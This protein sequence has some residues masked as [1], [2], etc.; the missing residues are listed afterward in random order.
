MTETTARDQ[1]LIG[2]YLAGRLT[3]TEALMVE[4]RIVEDSS[5]RSEVELS[6]A[7]KEGFRELEN[8]GQ[9]E[10]LL[11]G[12]TAS[13][14][15]R[16]VAIAAALTAAAVGFG[17]FLHERSADETAVVAVETLRFER[18][19]GGGI[20]PDVVWKRPLKS[21]MVEL[22]LDV[23]PDPAAKYR[24]TVRHLTNRDESVRELEASTLSSGEVS[25]T[26]ESGELKAG[27]IELRL[28]PV[29]TRESNIGETYM[30]LLE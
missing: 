6:A 17:I 18:T 3:D 24:V 28:V 15:R 7:L 8:R 20:Q 14:N 5:F 12:R 21:V 30:L 10:P 23:G 4:T 26:M 19:R 11:A 16:Q 29:G 25:V 13:G 2:R 9:I 22:R 1:E 27:I